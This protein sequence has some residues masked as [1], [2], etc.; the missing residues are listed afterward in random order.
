MRFWKGE[1]SRAF[2]DWR[3]LNYGVGYDAWLI[4]DSRIGFTL[5]KTTW[6]STV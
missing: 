5:E 1:C 3:G 4:E 6:P 2:T